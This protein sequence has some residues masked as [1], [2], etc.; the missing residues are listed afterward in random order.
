M[1][2]RTTITVMLV[3]LGPAAAFAGEPQSPSL[4]ADL[5]WFENVGQAYSQASRDML[6]RRPEAHRIERI[7]QAAEG[8]P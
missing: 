8:L 4:E 7:R 2:A 1:K 5:K 3:L 6:E